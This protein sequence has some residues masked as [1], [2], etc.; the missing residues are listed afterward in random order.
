MGSIGRSKV[1][2]AKSDR[3]NNPL[4]E[5]GVSSDEILAIIECIETHDPKEQE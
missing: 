4:I 3:G 1:G 2:L 5:K